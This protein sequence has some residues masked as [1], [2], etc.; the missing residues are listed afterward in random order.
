MQRTARA[1][2]KGLAE[3]HEELAVARCY[4]STESL[5]NARLRIVFGGPN[6]KE[7]SAELE[8]ASSSATRLAR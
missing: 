8:A 3:Q 6:E 5:A 7:M 4:M 2:K 1:P